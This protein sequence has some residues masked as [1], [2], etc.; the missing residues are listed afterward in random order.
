MRGYC[1][2][3]SNLPAISNYGAK[4]YVHTHLQPSRTRLLNIRKKEQPVIA[5]CELSQKFVDHAPSDSRS[6]VQAT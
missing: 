3:G 5:Y 6:P 2:D 1:A 4:F